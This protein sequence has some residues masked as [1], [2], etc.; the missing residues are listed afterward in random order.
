MKQFVKSM[1]ILSILPLIFISTTFE[2]A[3]IAG[4]VLVV[5]TM[6]I[7][8]LS[9]LIDKL[10]EGRFRTYTYVILTAGIVSLLNIILGTYISQTELYSIYFVLFILNVDLVYNPSEK[11]TAVKQLVISALSF[12]LIVF[13][14]LLR[15]V[16]GTG[17]LTIALF[18]VD[19]IQI[20]ASKYAISFLQQA[21]GGFVLAGFVFGIINSLD[22]I[23]VK[24]VAKDDIL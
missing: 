20:F 16:L 7:K 6:A 13:V 4:L 15:E 19:T 18:N 22:F 17:T 1:I 9:L 14:G 23:K 12:V 3:L 21:S 8:G 5:V 11:V 24:E 2:N 10:A